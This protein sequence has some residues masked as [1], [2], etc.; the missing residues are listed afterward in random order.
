MRVCV[1]DLRVLVPVRETRQDLRSERG[2]DE[3]RPGGR[4][5]GLRYRT[6]TPIEIRVG[7]GYIPDERG[8]RS[9]YALPTCGATVEV[10]RRGCNPDLRAGF[11]WRCGFFYVTFASFRLCV[12]PDRVSERDV[13][14]YGSKDLGVMVRTAAGDEAVEKQQ[15]DADHNGR[16]GEVEGG[17]VPAGVVDVDEVDDVAEA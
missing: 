10:V 8:F 3:A 11:D 4:P 5:T 14:A 13:P 1:R 16:V 15:D 6:T 12:K 2:N 7:P 17:P 9:V